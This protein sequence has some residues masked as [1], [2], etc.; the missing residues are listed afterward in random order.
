MLQEMKETV[1][2]ME[3]VKIGIDA[4]RQGLESGLFNTED[5]IKILS[6]ISEKI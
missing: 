6:R 5:A 3:D 1:K 2:T 4:L